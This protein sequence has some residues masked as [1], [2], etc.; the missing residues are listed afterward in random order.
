[1]KIIDK[2]KNSQENKREGRIK[3]TLESFVENDSIPA[4]AAKFIIAILALGPILF[5]GAAA[6]GIISSLSDIRSSRE[7]S[8]KQITH[9][10]YNLKRRKYLKII[11]DGNETMKAIITNEG[12]EKI[13]ELCFKI[14]SIKKPKSWDGK[15]RILAFDIPT[16][17]KIYNQARNALRQKVKELGFFKLQESL[18]VYPYECEDEILF[19]AEVYEVQG[20]VEILEVSRLLNEGKLKKVFKL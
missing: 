8:K 9:T 15:W 1:M 20:Y 3:E 4:T 2:E 5:V 17:P 7:Y 13:K 6:P 19:I 14:M 12:K 11:Q 16:K 18:W 10:F